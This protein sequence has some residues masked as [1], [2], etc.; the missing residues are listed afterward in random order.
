MNIYKYVA[1]EIV[2]NILSYDNRFVIRNGNV[3]NKLDIIKYKNIIQLLEFKPN[4]DYLVD[5]MCS[6]VKL[7]EQFIIIYYHKLDKYLFV[8]RNNWE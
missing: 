3:V 5:W 2:N 4:P 7:S 1:S 8:N 6:Y